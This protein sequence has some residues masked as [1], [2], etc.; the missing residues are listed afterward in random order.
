[1]PRITII[2]DDGVVGVDG[3]FREVDLAD[4]DPD[5]HAVQWDGAKGHIEFRTK[6]KLAKEVTSIT[7]FQKYIDRWNAVPPSPPFVNPQRAP[8]ERI[9][10]G[11]AGDVRFLSLVR[12]IADNAGMTE[13]QVIARMKVLMA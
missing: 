1:M 6:G 2:A 3:E 9:D 13:E 5:I 7:P 11:R 12:I 10:I 8:D 4:L